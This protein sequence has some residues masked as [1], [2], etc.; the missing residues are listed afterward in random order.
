MLDWWELDLLVH[1]QCLVQR[2][3]KDVCLIGR[4]RS[5]KFGVAV[6]KASML[7]WWE[8]DLPVHLQCLVQQYSKDVCLI[9]RG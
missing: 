2:Y 8:L 6:L 9:G 1:L 7:D 5:A 3:S 4:G